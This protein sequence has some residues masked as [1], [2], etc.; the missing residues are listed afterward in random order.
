VLEDEYCAAAIKYV[1]RNPVRAGL[2]ARAEEYPWSS[3]R[4]HILGLPDPLLAPCPLEDNRSSAEWGAWVNGAEEDDII[5]R[6][7]TNT[8]TGWPTGTVGFVAELEQRLGR[9]LLRH[10]AGRKSINAIP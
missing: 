4:A 7:R 3:A 10:R 6:L 5:E 9:R 1:E 2:V 8:F